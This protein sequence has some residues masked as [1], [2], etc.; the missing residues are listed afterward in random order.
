[1]SGPFR[2]PF[3]KRA[4][5]FG[6]WCCILGCKEEKERAIEPVF[7]EINHVSDIVPVD[8]MVK[9]IL[10]RNI[11]GFDTL[12]IQENKDKFV[13]AI[14]PAILIT[15]YR[16]NKDLGKIKEMVNKQTWDP[17]DSLFFSTQM[18]RFNANDSTDLI[19]RMHTHPTSIVL[20][21]AVVESGWGKSRFFSEAN[22]LFGIWSYNPDKPRIAA[23]S[24]KRNVH[25]RK[26]EDI[27]ES[28]MD[29]FETIARA[30]AYR[31]F[32][33]ARLRTSDV[34]EL[35][36]LL[37]SYSENRMG[38]V[39]QLKNIIEQNNFTQYDHYQLDPEYLVPL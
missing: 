11:G 31:S 23:G 3:L 26:Y 14:L 17:E 30:R 8:T 7:I 1:M 16:I 10:Y 29:Y 39:N 20:A 37:K 22:N 32:R 36:P 25:L 27:S 21:Q 13:A 2:P 4:I 18:E 15:R 34:N 19:V 5:Y 9:P 12:S 33:Q 6:L 28:V 35:L 24:S 38:Y